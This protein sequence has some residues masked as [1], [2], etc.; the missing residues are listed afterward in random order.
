MSIKVNS[1]GTSEMILA[2]CFTQRVLNRLHLP[3]SLSTSTRLLS[4]LPAFPGYQVDHR[5]KWNATTFAQR[6]SEDQLP[7]QNDQ[8]QS[9]TPNNTTPEENTNTRVAGIK[10][11]NKDLT[12]GI[13]HKISVLIQYSNLNIQ[14]LKP[15][16]SIPQTI[17]IQ[18]L[19]SQ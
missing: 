2:N 17:V 11:G 13:S 18:L 7:W 12:E 10:L 9:A 6:S 4:T 1:L 16:Y 5:R 14:Y 3:W 15:Q 19:L 8:T